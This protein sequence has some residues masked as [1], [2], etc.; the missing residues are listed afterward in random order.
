MT[1]IHAYNDYIK[2]YI[3]GTQKSLDKDVYRNGWNTQYAMGQNLAN[4]ESRP[5]L[6]LF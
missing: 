2:Y 1:Y 6:R 4:S 3:S 5:T